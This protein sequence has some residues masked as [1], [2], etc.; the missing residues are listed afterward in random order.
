MSILKGKVKEYAISISIP[1]WY[2]YELPN[3]LARSMLGTFQFQNGTIMSRNPFPVGSG[4]VYF[5]SKMVRLW[6]IEDK[7]K[8]AK[9]LISIPKWYDYELQKIIPARYRNNIS[10]PKWYDYEANWR[11]IFW[12]VWF[13]F[14]SKMVRL[15]DE[16]NENSLPS[17]VIS[18]PKWYDYEP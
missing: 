4:F 6:E 15:W 10:I 17:K 18:I 11:Y 12:N 5:N 7:I 1:K 3:F 16:K 14:N 2:D 8:I 9:K 13:D